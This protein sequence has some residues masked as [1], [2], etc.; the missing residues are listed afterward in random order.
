[1]AGAMAA[2]LANAQHGYQRRSIMWHLCSTLASGSENGGNGGVAS[3]AQP[4]H[5]G[6]ISVAAAI[7]QW[8]KS[9]NGGVSEE[10]EMAA[11][12]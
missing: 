9:R 2:G 8:R 12:Q 6:G 7:K 4:Q 5:H 10:S 11:W 3:A 1:M